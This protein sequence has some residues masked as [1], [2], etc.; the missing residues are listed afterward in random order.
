MKV[1]I[2]KNH[3]GFWLSDK[4]VE[5]LKN[6]QEPTVKVEGDVLPDEDKFDLIDEDSKEWR[7][8]PI[9]VSV[10]EKLGKE[11]YDEGNSLL[12]VVEI[13]FETTEGWHIANYDGIEAINEDHR[14][15]G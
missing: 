1:V 12:K 10:V 15:W 9:L 7:S 13:P 6:S 2:N 11:A 5:L 8:N 14:T 3:G 4:A